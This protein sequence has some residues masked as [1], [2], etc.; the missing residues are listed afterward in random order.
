[1]GVFVSG[2][3]GPTDLRELR[4][5]VAGF[6]VGGYVS[7]ADPVDFALDIVTVDGEPAAKR[8]KLS[9]KKQVYRTRDGGHHVGLADRSGP[10]D[11]DALLEPLLR[12]GELVR[13]FD[14]DAATARALDDAERVGYEP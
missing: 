14:L 2:G 4:D 6:G 12:D 13:E 5:H 3:L 10:A 9:G 8:G 7:N 11:G 1:V